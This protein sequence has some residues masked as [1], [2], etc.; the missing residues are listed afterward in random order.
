MTSRDIALRRLFSQQIAGEGFLS[1]PGLVKWMGCIRAE[2]FASARWAIGARIAGSTDDRILAAFNQGL[3][4]RM[5]ILQSVR[6]FICPED[7]HWMLAL[8]APRLKAVNSGL[9]TSL[10]MDHK[11]LSKGKRVIVRALEESPLTRA[12]LLEILGKNGIGVNEVR[13]GLLLMD[14][15][16]DAL[17]CTDGR[18]TYRLLEKVRPGMKAPDKLWSIAELTKRYFLS[19]GPATV[20]DFSAWS[21]LRM[22]D[23]RMGMEMTRQWLTSEVIDGQVYWFDPSL[24][25]TDLR[26]S[27]FLLPALDELGVAY[28]G[29][30][31]FKPMIVIDGHISGC[32]VPS[33]RKG[34][35]TIDVTTPVKKGS[36]VQKA[37]RQEAE[38]YS[39]FVNRRLVLH[40]R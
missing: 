10:G 6:H 16:L 18:Q 30:S 12:Q 37:I 1:A 8:T 15:E 4:L 40:F 7:V 28:A 22:E 29:N 9:F 11:L 35:V 5:H 38:R 14:A 39:K 31:L 3:L 34:S 21:G 13:L 32:W 20:H 25:P 19:R 23:V 33:L 24:I 36:A 2:D 26:Q 27:L 17:V